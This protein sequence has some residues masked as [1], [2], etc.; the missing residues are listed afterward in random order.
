MKA[1]Y[2]LIVVNESS[3]GGT[4]TTSQSFEITFGSYLD[5]SSAQRDLIEYE[6]IPGK[7]SGNVTQIWRSLKL[8]S[9]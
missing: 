4:S 6:K 1:I 5:F 8:I 9:N 7:I 3:N 2:E